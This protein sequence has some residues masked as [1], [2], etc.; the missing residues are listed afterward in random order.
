MLTKT[1]DG[2]EIFPEDRGSSRI[3]FA[4]ISGLNIPFVINHVSYSQP[5][6]YWI[7]L[8]RVQDSLVYFCA[9]EI[10]PEV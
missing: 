10:P 5:M 7:R 4:Q 6:F 8:A 9:L 1:K 2:V 3:G